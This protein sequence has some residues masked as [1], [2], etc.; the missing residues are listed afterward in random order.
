MKA[1]GYEAY[2]LLASIYFSTLKNHK[3]GGGAQRLLLPVPH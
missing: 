3:V 1:I 2:A